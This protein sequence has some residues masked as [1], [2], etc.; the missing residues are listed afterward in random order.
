MDGLQRERE[1]ILGDNAELRSTLEQVDKFLDII[2]ASASADLPPT[3]I[4]LRDRVK[5]CLGQGG[6]NVTHV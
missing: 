4:T 2:A 5:G 1:R 3:F 6:E